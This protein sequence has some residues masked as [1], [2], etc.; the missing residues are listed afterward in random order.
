[1]AKPRSSGPSLRS[2]LCATF[3]FALLLLTWP[4]LSGLAEEGW[5]PFSEQESARQRSERRARP[6]PAGPQ[7]Q[8]LA[9]MTPGYRAPTYHSQP[10][11]SRYAPPARVERGHLTSNSPSD[12]VIPPAGYGHMQPGPIPGATVPGT[13]GTYLNGPDAT[14]ASGLGIPQPRIDRG[15]LMPAIA[16]RGG[17]ITGAW[18]GISP[19]VAEE[20]FA[21]LHL[22]PASP[23][24][25]ILL[26]RILEEP[27][28]DAGLEE[29]RR[30][31]LFKAGRFDL[32]AAAQPGERR[33]A[34]ASAAI[35]LQSVRYDLV[36]GRRESGCSDIKRIAADPKKL[37]H[38]LRGEAV[39]IA[40]YCAVASGDHQAG[41]LAADLARNAG[42][43]RPFTIALFEAIG[44]G[45]TIEAEL[46]S[47][48]DMLDALLLRELKSPDGKL[49]AALAERGDAGF[50]QIL[51]SAS[52]LPPA[53]ASAVVEIAAL[54]N[55]AAPKAL[56]DVYR[57]AGDSKSRAKGRSARAV[58]RARHFATAERQQAQF[59]R[60]R[61]IRA[62]L[63]SARSDGLLN[64]AA[65]A[66]APIVAGMR[67]TEEISWFHETAVEILIA[68]G[69]YRAA[70]Q[71][72]A[73]A[74]PDR[75]VAGRLDHWLLLADIGMADRAGPERARGFAALENLARQGRIANTALHRLAT[76]LDALDYNI[77]I[78]LWNLASRTPQPQSG[79]L[80]E[81]G[82]L[83][84]LRQVSE[85]RQPG[86]TALYVLRTIAPKG[87]YA[88]HLLGLGEALR[89]LKRAGLEADAR[90]LAIEAL[91][92]DWPRSPP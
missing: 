55:V 1:M 19:A 61:A 86:H 26:Q 27:G 25:A 75:Q 15:G 73:A 76:V 62:L 63:D 37:P 16:D 64:V 69:D 56:A 7:A 65:A 35:A 28:G 79:H 60:T 70:R 10:G 22:P 87:T 51:S 38:R 80:P 18:T 77:P 52:N 43:R 72:I 48:A 41:S 89:A 12:P 39:L 67:P 31:A 88:T 42:A 9:P 4:P 49:A 8:P 17:P 58:E 29:V 32:L 71:W 66:V 84:A 21:S 44:R 36:T 45:G 83:S 34:P 24:L 47:R 5:N 90:R 40:G 3:V 74:A 85:A 92:A 46:P 78:P 30:A 54:R 53:A 11:Y 82:L 13:P 50:L 14:G 91:Y 33:S 6:V 2:I 23:A 68:G 81:T 59:V 57:R 20:L